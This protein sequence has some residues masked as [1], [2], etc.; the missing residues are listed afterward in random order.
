MVTAATMS[1]Q[2]SSRYSNPPVQDTLILKKSKQ[3]RLFFQNI[4]NG[5]TTQQVLSLNKNVSGPPY[6][7]DQPFNQSGPAFLGRI[8]SSSKPKSTNSYKSVPYDKTHSP[9]NANGVCWQKKM[10]SVR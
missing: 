6:H 9:S 4:L 3:N 8:L 7:F 2:A 10:D 1:N 5:Q